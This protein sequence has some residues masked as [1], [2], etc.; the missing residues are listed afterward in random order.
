MNIGVEGNKMNEEIKN[1]TKEFA[2]AIL[3]SKEY[4]TFIS[5]TDDLEK[6]ED[7]NDLLK[8]FQKKQMELQYRGFDPSLMEELRELQT[9]I[10][11]NEIIQQFANAQNELVDLLKRTNNIISLRINMPF[12]SA[13]RGGC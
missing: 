12:V 5:A 2:Q 8:D 11:R 1:K 13:N 10:N 4:K 9:K 3:E 7:A 6:N